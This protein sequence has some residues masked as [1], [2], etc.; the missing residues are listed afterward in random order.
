MMSKQT[1][2]GNILEKDVFKK[3]AP[4]MTYNNQKQFSYNVI[5]FC[6]LISCEEEPII[7]VNLP[8]ST[9]HLLLP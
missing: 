9:A 7:I 4:L 3:R 2:S 8:G 6:S 1:F 5:S